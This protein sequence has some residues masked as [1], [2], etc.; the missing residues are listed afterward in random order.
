MPHCQ[1]DEKNVFAI[2]VSYYV[3]VKL[4]LSGM[5]GELSLKLPFTLAHVDEVGT[6]D[7]Q[8]QSVS[9]ECGGATESASQMTPDQSTSGNPEPGREKGLVVVAEVENHNNCRS[10][11][12]APTSE[13]SIT[14]GNSQTSS[15]K[16]ETALPSVEDTN[17][18]QKLFNLSSALRQ[19]RFSQV[20]QEKIRPVDDSLER[21]ETISDE[22]GPKL[23]FDGFSNIQREEV[24]LSSSSAEIGGVR[25]M[26]SS[27]SLEETE[28]LDEVFCKS[29]TLDQHPM[30]QQEQPQEVGPLKTSSSVST[31][32][33]LVKVN[34]ESLVGMGER[35]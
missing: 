24:G 25:V 22:E 10:S 23:P 29:L 14:G 4:T 31:S 8:R 6:R 32:S 13:E 7:S 26:G 27:G 11:S 1:L 15:S 28:L 34:S 12:Q 21:I 30:Q 5:G 19:R 33:S 17:E 16:G 20:R 2:Y 9:T 3:K 18:E 35:S